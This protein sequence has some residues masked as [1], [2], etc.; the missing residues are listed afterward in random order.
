M[1]T[2]GTKIAE[3]RRAKTMTQEELAGIIGVSSQSISKW[4]NNVTMPDIL[5]LPLI[6]DTFGIT[7]DGLFRDA[8]PADTHWLR[9]DEVPEAAHTAIVRSMAEAFKRCEEEVCTEE[10]VSGWVRELLDAYAAEN[11]A[12]AVYTDRGEIAYA[13]EGL[14][15]VIRRRGEN[16]MDDLLGD[17]KIS[18]IL[19]A[20]AS[21]DVRRLLAL[22]MKNSDVK[23]T[24][25]S[26]AK[27]LGI[28]E[29][30]AEAAADTLVGLRLMAAETLALA[31]EG[32]IAL[33]SAVHA[34]HIGL[35]YGILACASEMVPNVSYRGYRGTLMK[36]L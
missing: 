9:F 2:I 18:L 33:Y 21:E 6:A 13:T 27:K 20:L 15:L 14:G 35:I 4:E 16:G 1:T 30:D 31:D 3:L 8:P 22:V 11:C 32:C 34:A 19:K 17:E 5:L 26:L 10:K 36:N 24:V 12:T 7:I 29:G 28:G 23:Y 25:P